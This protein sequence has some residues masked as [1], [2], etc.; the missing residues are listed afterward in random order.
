MVALIFADNT[1][2]FAQQSAVDS[3][4]DRNAGFFNITQIGHNRGIGQYSFRSDAVFQNRGYVN[5]LRTTLG[6]FLCPAFSVGL[7]VG[8]DRY[9]N[10]GY[11]TASLVTDFRYYTRPTASSVFAVATAGYLLL[12]SNQFAPGATG[13]LGV[14]YRFILGR[15][16]HLLLSTGLETHQIRDARLFLLGPTSVETLQSNLWLKSVSFNT[17]L[18]F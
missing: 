13:G 18:L 3:K 11:N 6:Y 16:T 2:T 15:G 4:K 9:E 12:L 7:G 5:R 8:L 17:G 14:G 10:P 1:T